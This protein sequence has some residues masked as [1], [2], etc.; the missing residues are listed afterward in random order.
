MVVNKKFKER[1]KKS[2]DLRK[3]SSDS[4]LRG[5]L[6]K[7]FGETTLFAVALIFF[8]ATACP[9]HAAWWSTDSEEERDINSSNIPQELQPQ[10]QEILR[11]YAEAIRGQVEDLEI[12]P[13]LE[14]DA[15]IREALKGWEEE[16]GQT[17]DWN[18]RNKQPI[19]LENQGKQRF[20]SCSPSMRKSLV[21]SFE[22]S[23]MLSSVSQEPLFLDNKYQFSLEFRPFFALSRCSRS[24]QFGAV[25]TA[26]KQWESQYTSGHILYGGSGTGGDH[27]NNVMGGITY[28]RSLS[29]S[30]AAALTLTGG[31]TWSE[32]Q[33]YFRRSYYELHYNTFSIGLSPLIVFYL[34]TK[35]PL[36]LFLGG[37]VHFS[38]R[39][40]S[41]EQFK[42]ATFVC[43]AENSMLWRVKAGP[44]YT[45]KRSA[46][47]RL[48]QLRFSIAANVQSQIPDRFTVAPNLLFE[49]QGHESRGGYLFSLG[50][51]LSKL[52]KSWSLSYG[53]RF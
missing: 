22:M 17:L 28:G 39:F 1:V 14:V 19:L 25:L 44:S 37:D 38:H 29:D 15:L 32:F 13:N 27:N 48:Y 43:A 47:K 42:G 10:V 45:F 4:F 46:K 18:H 16:T 11:D 20:H 36:D 23:A 24:P 35:I 52:E 31:F 34:P 53:L 6:R 12:E 33:K 49:S 5:F 8:T 30:F 50:F 21:S 2:T 3:T 7:S 9:G 40:C 51:D 26:R 41:E